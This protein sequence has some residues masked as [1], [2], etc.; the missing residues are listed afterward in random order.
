MVVVLSLFFYCSHAIWNPDERK[1]FQCA[2]NAAMED[3]LHRDQVVNN[4]KQTSNTTMDASRPDDTL[5][6]SDQGQNHVAIIVNFP[7]SLHDHMFWQPPRYHRHVAKLCL[8]LYSIYYYPA[9]YL[10]FNY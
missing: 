5:T 1:F 8:H 7:Q 2:R 3:P 10:F 4:V 6:D 9:N